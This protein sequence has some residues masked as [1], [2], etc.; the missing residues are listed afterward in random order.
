MLAT[1]TVNVSMP[2][3]LLGGTVIDAHGFE[4]VAVPPVP[5]SL[6]SQPTFEP[7]EAVP[8]AP[9]SPCA[10]D[11]GELRIDIDEHRPGIGVLA[12]IAEPAA[13]LAADNPINNRIFT[14][15]ASF[16]EKRQVGLGGR[17]CNAKA[18]ILIHGVDILLSNYLQ[19]GT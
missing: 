2:S 15:P 19:H 14:K 8:F 6:A 4:I 18:Y 10:V 16:P 12:L 17:R 13:H 3:G 11:P 5:E 9:E 7:I 1:T